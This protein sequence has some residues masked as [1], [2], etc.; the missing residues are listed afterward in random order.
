MG[1]AELA[2]PTP[3]R[4]RPKLRARLAF[5]GAGVLL[6]L[7]SAEIGARACQGPPL[8]RPG[9]IQDAELGFHPSPRERFE[10]YD[11]RGE[12]AFVTNTLGFR[13]RDLP[14]E[15][16]A[17]PPG[18]LRLLFVGDSFVFGHAVRDE[19]LVSTVCERLLAERSLRAEAF[20]LA[21]TDYGTLQELLLLRRYGARARPEVVVLLVFT[22][23]DVV[24]NTL[25]FAGRY[26][27]DYLR[28][29]FVAAGEEPRFLHPLRSALRHRLRSFAVLENHF[30]GLANARGWTGV[31][32][33][34]LAHP[35]PEEA[36]MRAPAP[37]SAWDTGWR[38]TEELLGMFRDEARALGAELLVVVVPRRDQV[39][40]EGFNHEFFGRVTSELDWNYPE[41]RLQAFLE[42][43]GIA[44][45]ILLED[46]RAAIAA[47]PTP[48]FAQ[49]FHFSP[50]GHAIAARRIADWVA[51]RAETR[52]SV[53]AELGAPVDLLAPERCLAALDFV[54]AP[55][56]EFLVAGFGTWRRD[57]EGKGPGVPMGR[58][59]K[60]YLRVGTGDFVVR[61]SCL[62]QRAMPRT[63]ELV[64]DGK[65]LARSPVIERKGPFELRVP[66]AELPAELPSRIELTLRL[67]GPEAPARAVPW[68]LIL[69]QIGFAEALA[70]R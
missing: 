1:S 39:Q 37:G 10:G 21:C 47:D 46:L 55:R 17:K 38:R 36:L 13:G 42:R 22:G 8:I 49:D 59:A 57:W 34:N 52:T 9:V 68:V 43:E 4:P 25:E 23:N 29:Y 7:V 54:S 5:A 70:D 26:D 65:A 45:V 63:L 16:S 66:R 50:R 44:A 67:S 27:G 19:E 64:F 69:R 61:G 31:K 41:R 12:F 62:A 20:D 14:E 32:W 60:L 2:A 33:G 56:F 28:P 24:N 11:E 6:A 58:E 48:V 30:I 3:A 51:R 15:G 53:N 18:R 35:A 40:H